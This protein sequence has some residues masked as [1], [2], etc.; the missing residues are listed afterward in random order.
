MWS[1]AR[2]RVARGDVAGLGAGSGVRVYA[3]NVHWEL[4]GAFTG[5]ISAPMLLELGVD[6]DDRRALRAAAA[7]WRDRR[8]R[9]PAGR[10][11][12]RGRP[13]RHRVC[14]RDRGRAGGGKD[15]GRARPAG[16]A[17]SA[18]RAARHRVRARMG[19]RDRQDRHARDRAGGACLRQVAAPAPVLYGGSVKPENAAALLALPDVDG[20]LVG[21]ASLDLPVF[22][23]DLP[24][25]CR[26][27]VTPV[28]LVI[29][30]GWGIAP[31]GPGNAVE[32]A[33]TPVF[34]A[35]WAGYPH[36]TLAASGEAVGLPRG[37]WV[38]PRSAT[39]RS[40]RAGSSSRISRA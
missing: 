21:G 6:R 36:G 34:D 7:F 28:V 5:E 1:S 37:R 23:G 14:R 19:D 9:E 13:A 39:S 40:A 33:E 3:Q 27:S 11:S 16:G 4:E 17:R 35:L 12:A 24:R 25:G 26:R 29:L 30:D 32:L 15:R 22:R 18:P 31:P 20:A 2:R 8:D 10:G 38:T